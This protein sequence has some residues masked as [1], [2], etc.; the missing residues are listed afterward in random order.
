[1]YF[2]CRPSTCYILIFLSAQNKIYTP[3]KD[4]FPASVLDNTF[5]SREY[6]LPHSQRCQCR[7]PIAPKPGPVV[8][9]TTRIPVR[10][11]WHDTATSSCAWQFIPSHGQLFCRLQHFISHNKLAVRP[12]LGSNNTLR[13]VNNLYIFVSPFVPGAV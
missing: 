8:H 4:G 11:A 13:S 2:D 6:E 1:M 12:V 7:C 10:P 9:I 5:C 3:M